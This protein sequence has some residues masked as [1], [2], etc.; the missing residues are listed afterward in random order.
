MEPFQSDILDYALK[1]VTSDGHIKFYGGEP[2]V[3]FRNQ[4]ESILYLR[5]KGFQ[6][7]MTIFTN[8]IEFPKLKEILEIDPQITLA[9]N[10]SIY[11]ERDTRGL[12]PVIRNQIMDYQRQFPNR[13]YLAHP[14]LIPSG[15]GS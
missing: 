7:R 9:L 11:H 3:N 15:R 1:L 2:T 10:Y 6:G 13:I 4:K 14:D 8:G 5:Q 12:P